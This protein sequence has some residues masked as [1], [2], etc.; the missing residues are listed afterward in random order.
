MENFTNLGRKRSLTP[1]PPNYAIQLSKQQ[2][3][4]KL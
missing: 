4:Y 2:K 3:G 1:P